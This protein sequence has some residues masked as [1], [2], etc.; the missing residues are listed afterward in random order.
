[1]RGLPITGDFDG[2]GKTDLG[3]YSNGKFYFDLAALDPGGH[4]TGNTNKLINVQPLLPNSIGFANVQLRP[5]A[6]DLDMDGIT[7][8]GLFVPGG[9]AATPSGTSQWYALISNDPTG[10]KRSPGS[11]STLDHAFDPKP[12]GHDLVAVFGNEFALPIVGNFDPPADGQEVVGGWVAN[13]YHDVLGRDPSYDE[14]HAWSQAIDNGVVT[15]KAVATLFLSSPERR[16]G[17][18][19]DLYQQYLGREVDAAGLNYWLAIWQATGGPE[20][21]QAGIIGS[22]EYYRTA[23]Q[24]HPNLTPDEAWVTA[25]YEKI[26][27][28]EVVAAGLAFWVYYIQ[29]HSK[30]C[31]V[32][33]FVTS[34]E[35]RLGL[36][37]GWF[38][39]YLGRQLDSTGANYW[40]RQMQLGATQES[41]QAGIL[42]SA[43]YRN[44]S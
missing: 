38:S 36:I 43:E 26:L 18:I 24:M 44:R 22:V 32:I 9:T 34:D 20:Q 30:Q 37:Q 19:G 15:P 28:R 27:Y 21:V 39:S 16:G 7:D 1:M 40:L 8:I 6:A 29:S 25:L 2:D 11:V 5:I 12:L 3:T 42:A 35:Y 23:G 31:V 41:I 10:A 17:I 14:W 4:L 33:G 13:L